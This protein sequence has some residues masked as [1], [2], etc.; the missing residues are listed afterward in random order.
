MSP[1]HEIKIQWSD[2]HQSIFQ[3]SFFEKYDLNGS[4]GDHQGYYKL[5][6]ILWKSD[7]QV[8]KFNFDEILQDEQVMF[9]W[10]DHVTS[11]GIAI[12]E[13]L[14]CNLEA[15]PALLKTIFHPEITHYGQYFKVQDKADANN[16]AYTGKTIG[17]H[18]DQPYYEKT[19]SV[20]F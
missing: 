9:K 18:V 20:R 19:P 7:H 2:G 15:L 17:F 6:P 16:L 3:P 12:V 14:P 1:D 13:G 10:L 8:A 4:S 11:H 5:R